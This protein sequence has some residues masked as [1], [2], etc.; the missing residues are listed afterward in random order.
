MNQ[1]GLPITLDSKMLLENLVGNEQILDF[2]DQIYLQQRST[3]IYVYGETGRGKTHLLQ[4]A[5]SR[6]L[7]KKKNGMYIDCNEPIPEHVIEYIDQLDWISIDN[8]NLIGSQQHLFFDLYNRGKIAEVSM[9]ISGPTPP[10]NL[11]IMKDLK[12]RL[13]LA[14]VFELEELNDDLTREVLKNQMS[15][16]NLTIEPKVYEY[17]FKYYSRNVNI[18]ISAINLLDRASLQS[19]QGITIPFVK[20]TLDL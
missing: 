1:L 16:R 19:K 13:G 7:A 18:L 15:E 3:E 6:T 5:I 9:L 2:I 10:N 11:S 12:T 17:L 14:A 8:V 4:G 20:K